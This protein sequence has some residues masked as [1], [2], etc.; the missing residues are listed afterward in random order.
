MFM[1]MLMLM[2][3]LMLSPMRNTLWRYPPSTDF[4]LQPLQQ[5]FSLTPLSNSHY[6]LHSDQIGAP[7]CR[8]LRARAIGTCRHPSG[9]GRGAMS[10]VFPKRVPSRLCRSPRMSDV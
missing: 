4:L 2:L 3:M 8:R 9:S 5:I 10:L 6:T 7:I 1:F